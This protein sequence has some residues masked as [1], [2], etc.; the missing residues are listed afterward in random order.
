MNEK[1]SLTIK[2]GNPSNRAALE[3]DEKAF[4]IR[5]PFREY[6]IDRCSITDIRCT[7][8]KVQRGRWEYCMIEL[9]IEAN[10][11]K[12][13]FSDYLDDA[14]AV[15]IINGKEPSVP[16]INMYEFLIGKKLILPKF[17][18]PERSDYI[19][20]KINNINHLLILFL[21]IASAALIVLSNIAAYIAVICIFIFIFIFY[22]CRHSTDVYADS[23]QLLF[24]EIFRE[25]KVMINDIASISAETGSDKMHLFP[26]D[27]IRL[28]ITMKDGRKYQ[29]NDKLDTVSIVSDYI[30]GKS[31]NVPLIQLYDFLNSQL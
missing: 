19:S 1:I 26:T 27:T 7:P 28:I 3:A 31:L 15:N 20:I 30:N 2:S 21:F 24:K 11:E 23:S 29:L 12:Y 13:I 9:Y 10:G 5:Y 14:A 22:L 4:R 18:R 6:S 17:A 8:Y 25:N 16:L